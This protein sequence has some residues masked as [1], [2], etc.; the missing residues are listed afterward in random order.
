MIQF[1]KNVMIPGGLLQITC[2]GAGALSLDARFER[3]RA[4]GPRLDER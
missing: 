3:V 1:L 4:Y 2:F